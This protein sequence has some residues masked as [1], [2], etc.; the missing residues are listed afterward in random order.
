MEQDESDGITFR[1]LSS[2]YAHN[3]ITGG[4]NARVEL[5]CSATSEEL[6]RGA[7]QRLDGHVVHDVDNLSDF[8]ISMAMEEKQKLEEE[9]AAA[10]RETHAELEALRS[11]LSFAEAELR[12]LKQGQALSRGVPWDHE[13]SQP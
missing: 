10:K 12:L 1:L 7:M 9:L 4:V 3:P 6:I 11:R 5:A 13:E 2:S 8:M